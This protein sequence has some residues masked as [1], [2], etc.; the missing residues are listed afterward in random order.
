[1]SVATGS[2]ERGRVYA[3]TVRVRLS[4][5]AQRTVELP[6]HDFEIWVAGGD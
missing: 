1:M 6:G 3:G 5:D 2:V 4:Y